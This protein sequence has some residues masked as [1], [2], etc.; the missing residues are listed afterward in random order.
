MTYRLAGLVFVLLSSNGAWALPLT[1]Y[2]GNYQAVDDSSLTLRLEASGNDGLTGALDD[3]GDVLPI[4]AK[5]TDD[6]L[7]G[8]FGDPDDAMGFV[9]TLSGDRLV[10]EVGDDEYR[11][12]VVFLKAGSATGELQSGGAA[13]APGE[14]KINGR[15]LDQAAIDRAGQQYGLKI[16]AG[17]YWYDPVLGAW[18]VTGGPAYGFIAPGLDLG[19]P[20]PANAS[21]GGTGIF[22]NGRELHPYDVYA[23][24]TITGPIMHGR[25]FITPDGLAGFEGG[26][27]LWNLLALAARS[28]GGGGGGGSSTWQSRITGASGFSDGDSGAVFLPNGGI[29]SY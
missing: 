2:V 21:G 11:E 9:G 27:P 5:L 4:E 10:L 6:G 16:P 7:S 28:G 13:P 1:D 15:V 25:Y 14:V 23:L 18:G 22:V 17:D 19:G 8:R 12:Q 26:P 24:Q 3:Y 29:V 20:V